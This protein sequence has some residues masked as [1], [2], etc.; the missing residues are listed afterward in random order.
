M[1]YI[2][3]YIILVVACDSLWYK[4]PD[5]VQKQCA[6]YYITFIHFVTSYYIYS[7][8]LRFECH[9]LGC[10]VPDQVQK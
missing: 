10:K 9:V 6:Q 8:W 2:Y 7:F 4:V 3:I 5:Q 1:L